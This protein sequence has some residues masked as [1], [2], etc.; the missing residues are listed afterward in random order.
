MP[1][2]PDRV[3][4]PAVPLWLGAGGLVPF[5]LLAGALWVV[6]AEF[7]PVIHD[8]L[9]TYAA[10]I[11]SF[12]GAIHWGIAMTHRDMADADRSVVMGWSIVPALVAWVG[13]LMQ[14]RAGI[15]L[16]AAMFVVHYSMDRQLASR[17]PLPG[18]YL[19]L[20]RGLT[21]VVVACMAVAAMR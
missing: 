21:V 5:V 15:V 4:V 19:P 10:V 17:F 16:T 3:P 8:W 14:L 9:R 2:P 7:H 13:L 1:L 12:I 6:P 18:W 11:L 20:R